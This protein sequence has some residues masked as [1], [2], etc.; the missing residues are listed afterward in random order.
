M[1][2]IEE[3]RFL[4]FRDNGES[5]TTYKNTYAF[6][7]VSSVVCLCRLDSRHLCW[8]WLDWTTRG[9]APRGRRAV[10]LAVNADAERSGMQSAHAQYASVGSAS[11]THRHHTHTYTAPSLP[12]KLF[13]TF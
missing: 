13:F 2:N 1:S 6:F 5:E 12:F 8:T 11:P 9:D 3:C 4:L 7:V 10:A